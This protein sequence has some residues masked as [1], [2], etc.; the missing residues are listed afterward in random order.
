VS[1]LAR[2]NEIPAIITAVSADGDHGYVFVQEAT[3]PCFGC[4]FP[5]AVND[6][7]YP[8]PGTPAIADI[9]EA[10]GSLAVYALDTLFM[11][12]PRNWNYRRIRLSDG[13][14]DCSVRIAAREDCPLA[15]HR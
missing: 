6:E 14:F 15:C 10:V 11:E 2:Q 3:G 7:R 4:L 5:D 1:Y 12:R 13:A 8:C 9:L